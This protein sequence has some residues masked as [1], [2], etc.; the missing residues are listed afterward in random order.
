ML[1]SRYDSIVAHFDILIVCIPQVHPARRPNERL[2]LPDACYIIVGGTSGI[3]LDIAGWLPQKGARHVILVSRSGASN[4]NTLEAIE[5]LQ[6]QGVTVTVCQCDI[7]VERDVVRV[8]T[9]VLRSTPRVRGVIY[10]AM[11]LRVCFF[12]FISRLTEAFHRH[13]NHE[14]GYII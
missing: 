3:G 4:S 13:T 9:P 6:H 1:W 10:G 5:D 8:L 12:P 11:V 2:L 7:G 14:I